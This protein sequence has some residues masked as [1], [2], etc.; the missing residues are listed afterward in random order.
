MTKYNANKS[1]TWTPDDKFEMNGE[2][3][4]LILNAFRAI[5]STEEAQRV[6]LVNKANQAVEEVIVNAVENNI[7]KEQEE[8][9]NDI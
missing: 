7:I 2:Q 9:K 8:V 5:L 1:Y 3:F 4:G 6:L